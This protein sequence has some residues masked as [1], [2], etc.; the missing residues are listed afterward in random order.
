MT[1]WVFEHGLKHT[2][3][4]VGPRRRVTIDAT[5]RC[6]SHE[7]DTNEEATL[8]GEL[9]LN[10]S[11]REHLEEVF[12]SAHLLTLGRSVGTGPSWARVCFEHDGE[13]HEMVVLHRTPEGVLEPAHVVGLAKAAHPILQAL[14]YHLNRFG[15]VGEGEIADETEVRGRP[16][17]TDGEHGRLLMRFTIDDVSRPDRMWLKL[18]ESGIGERR[19]LATDETDGEPMNE[20]VF[21]I[22]SGRVAELF[23]LVKR[24][25]PKGPPPESACA[26]WELY[27][28]GGKRDVRTVVLDGDMPSRTGAPARVAAVQEAFMAFEALLS[29]R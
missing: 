6:I 19:L 21:P 29:R 1:R 3:P 23:E 17:S 25:V 10:E 22:G 24:H 20:P 4:G 16:I 2:P 7:L 8:N 26:I 13:A 5:G 11:E 14:L 15:T 9:Q 27:G 28:V 18:F 12:Q